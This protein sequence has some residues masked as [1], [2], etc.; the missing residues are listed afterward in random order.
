MLIFGRSFDEGQ[1][2]EQG[3]SHHVARA[4]RG[5]FAIICLADVVGFS[6]ARVQLRLF[7]ACHRCVV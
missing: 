5:V 7:C 6:F 2:S 1:E 3:V 4:V